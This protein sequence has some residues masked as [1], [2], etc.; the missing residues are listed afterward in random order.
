[1]DL[2]ATLR[3]LFAAN[4]D[5]TAD[6]L[7]AMLDDAR[8]EAAIQK[9]QVDGL[10]PADQ[11]T[12]DAAKAIRTT[13]PDALDILLR[14]QRPVPTAS[15]AAATAALTTDPIQTQAD[16]LGIPYHE[17]AAGGNQP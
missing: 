16:A 5:T 1:M 7:R 8:A 15:T 10:L 2:R 14:A 3:D 4:P 13:H 6:D 11:A 9:Y 17:A 12:L